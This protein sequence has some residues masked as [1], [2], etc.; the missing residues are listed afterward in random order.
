V[1]TLGLLQVLSTVGNV[2][3]VRHQVRDRRARSGTAPSR[4]AGLAV[5]VPDRPDPAV[6]VVFSYKHLS[7]PAGGLK[8]KAEGRLPRGSILVP[9]KN[10]IRDTTAG[11]GT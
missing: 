10:L 8:L 6:M 4:P 9:Y 3:A 11:G 2:L 5:D 1:Q 7:E